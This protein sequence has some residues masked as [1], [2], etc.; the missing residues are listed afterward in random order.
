MITNYS[1]YINEKSEYG[2]EFIPINVYWRKDSSSSMTG[3]EMKYLYERTIQELM[4]GK[5][6][7]FS[8][9]KNE[10]DDDGYAG[11]HI[12][13]YVRSVDLVSDTGNF[14][15]KMKGLFGRTYILDVLSKVC[16]Y[17]KKPKSIK[18][19]IDPFGEEMWDE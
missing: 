14:S 18:S 9:I 13:G 12:E 15:I 8:I 4:V 7:T 1:T 10:P 19:D 17:N 3:A 6:A 5:Y 2:N 16:V 11:G